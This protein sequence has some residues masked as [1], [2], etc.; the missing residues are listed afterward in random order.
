MVR[1]ALIDPFVI[2]TRALVAAGHAASGSRILLG[3]DEN[4]K[5]VKAVRTW[6]WL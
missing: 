3:L 6:A 2:Y 4:P 1:T 5:E